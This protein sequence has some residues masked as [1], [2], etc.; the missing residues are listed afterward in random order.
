MRILRIALAAGIAAIPA[1]ASAGETI[2]YT[3]DVHG[4]LQKVARSGTVNNG[5]VTTYA[6]D[7]ADNRSSKSTTGSATTASISSDAPLSTTSEPVSQTTE[8]VLDASEPALDAS[9]P[10][11][12]TS[13]PTV[14]SPGQQ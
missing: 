11:P 14:S 2:D 12:E 3:Y 8:P 1:A 10:V 6:H 4:R 13:D 9:E 5:V 7:K